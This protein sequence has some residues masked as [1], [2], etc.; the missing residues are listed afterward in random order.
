VEPGYMLLVEAPTLTK[1][2]RTILISAEI[3]CP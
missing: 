2:A 1:A 3:F